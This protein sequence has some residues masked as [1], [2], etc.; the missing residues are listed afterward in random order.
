MSSISNIIKYMLNDEEFINAITEKI[1]DNL[2]ENDFLN[3]LDKQISDIYEKNNLNLNSDIDDITEI[4]N[5]DNQVID[6][7]TEN[8]SSHKQVID[9]NTE[10]IEVF[11][12]SKKLFFELSIIAYNALTEIIVFGH[13]NCYKIVELITNKKK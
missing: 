3:Q 10:N 12:N 4:I 13:Q 8:T 7:N 5:L 11:L 9:D 1:A 2:K 6:D